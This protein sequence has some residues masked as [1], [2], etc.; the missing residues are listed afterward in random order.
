MAEMLEVYGEVGVYPSIYAFDIYRDPERDLS[1]IADELSEAAILKIRKERG[2][3]ICTIYQ[4]PIEDIINGP[5]AFSMHE[6]PLYSNYALINATVPV[7]DSSENCTITVSWGFPEG[8]GVVT[9]EVDGNEK[10]FGCGHSTEKE[11]NWIVPNKNFKFRLYENSIC[12]VTLSFGDEV[13]FV[14]V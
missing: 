3:K 7:C 10:F 11:A 14:I 13:A 4:W 1:R 8:V 9:V 6:T 5:K 12:P 2:L